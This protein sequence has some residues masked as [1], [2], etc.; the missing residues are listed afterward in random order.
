MKL[1]RLFVILFALSFVA[2]TC[3]GPTPTPTPTPITIANSSVY[4]TI[5]TTNIDGTPLLDLGGFRIYFDLTPGT[6]RAL[7]DVKDPTASSL[8][9][10]MFL[11]QPGTYY[12]SIT[13]VDILGVESEKSK[14]VSFTAQ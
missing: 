5:P 10:N 12:L 14:E 1:L 2:A 6:Y 3:P 9:L 11:M 4:W 8:R 7:Y 13:A